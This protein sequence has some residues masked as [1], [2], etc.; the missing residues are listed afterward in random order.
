MERSSS[1][2]R[3][4]QGRGA[5]PPLCETLAVDAAAV[6]RPRLAATDIAR[7]L[8]R[9]ATHEGKLYN[10]HFDFFRTDRLVCTEIVYRAFDGLG[11]LD[12]EL[13]H[14]AGRPT[15]SAEDLL[16]LARDGRAFT[17]VAVVLGAGPVVAGAE[18]A[19][20]LAASYRGGPLTG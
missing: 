20:T 7:G 19:A 17:P 13:R 18:A 10:F 5:L 16:D 6:V 4:A 1:G 2:A 11:G 12:I 3:G 15:L 9:A 8:T 14:R